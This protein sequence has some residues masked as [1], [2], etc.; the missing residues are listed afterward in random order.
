MELVEPIGYGLWGL[1]WGLSGACSVNREWAVGVRV[2]LKVEFVQPIGY[3]LW[4][5]GWGLSGACRA[6]R[7][8]AVGLGWRLSGACTSNRVWAMGVRVGLKW[9][10]YIQ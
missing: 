4:W 7:V 9:S 10:L 5:L 2:G 6:N 8:C 1:G 3:G